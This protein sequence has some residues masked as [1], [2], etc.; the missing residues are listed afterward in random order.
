MGVARD[1]PIPAVVA[2]GRLLSC[3][4]A[5]G[6]PA[7]QAGVKMRFDNKDI[8]AIPL[9][10]GQEG[11]RLGAAVRQGQRKG[12]R[13]KKNRAAQWRIEGSAARCG[14]LL[15]VV[16]LWHQPSRS[17]EGA[18][19]FSCFSRTA[20]LHLERLARAFASRPC[21]IRSRMASAPVGID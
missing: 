19:S 13:S 11:R 6:G 10:Y 21:R 20:G 8:D 18:G 2:D 15:F 1:G 16:L 3:R 9:S 12:F 5:A 17:A 7:P 4:A 14:W